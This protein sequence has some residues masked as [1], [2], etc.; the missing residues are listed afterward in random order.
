MFEDIRRDGATAARQGK[1]L[2][3]CPFFKAE[4]M[5]GHTGEPVCEWHARVDAW[6]RGW[7]E[8]SLNRA[9]KHGIPIEWVDGAPGGKSRNAPGRRG[10]P[11]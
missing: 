3:D 11:R 4:C 8:A 9:E 2:L 5:P 6:E 1:S 7:R 10:V